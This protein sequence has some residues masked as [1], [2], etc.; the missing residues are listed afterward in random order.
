MNGFQNMQPV[1]QPDATQFVLDPIYAVQYEGGIK[2]EAFNK[3]LTASASYYNITI[4]NATR[5]NATGFTEQDGKQVSKG[6]DFEVLATP[7]NG[8]NIIAGYGYND[9]RIVKASDPNIEGNKATGSPENVVNFWTSYTFQN[10]LKGLGV[11]LG[12]NYVD[13]NF[14]TADNTFYMPSYT[15]LNGSVYYDHTS[16]RVG[17]KFNN[18]TNERYWDFWGTSQAPTNILASL[19]IKF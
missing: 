16:W 15:T 13:K 10:K 14:F 12:A 4:D 3:K 9:N 1:T 2:A 7:I 19:T 5:V 17:L 11:G 8:L 6:F 18:I